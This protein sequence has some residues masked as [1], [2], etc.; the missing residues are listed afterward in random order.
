MLFH[1]PLMLPC[2][3]T[4][5]ENVLIKPCQGL[6]RA[7]GNNSH[8]FP[9]LQSLTAG[10]PDLL[11]KVASPSTLSLLLCPSS[12]RTHLWPEHSLLTPSQASYNTPP[13]SQWAR[14]VSVTQDA[15]L[16]HFPLGEDLVTAP[17]L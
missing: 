12:L 15:C 13:P 16:E 10:V 1:T 2:K 9:L 14:A 11:V 6:T 8:Y 17:H 3:F 4:D 5:L 7:L